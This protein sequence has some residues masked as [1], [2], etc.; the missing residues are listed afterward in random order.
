[1]IA[2]VGGDGSLS[3][4]I[5]GRMLLNGSQKETFA[6]IPAGT[7][8]SQAHDLKITSTED[9]V[10]A[11]VSGRTQALDLAKVELTE[12]LPGETGGGLIRYSHNLVTWGLGVDSTIQAEKMRWMGP[13]RYD[14]G[15]LLAIMANRRRTATLSLDGRRITDDFTLF[16]VQNSQTGAPNFPWLRVRRWTMGKWTSAFSRK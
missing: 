15:I 11:I 14:V 6:I 9:A 8:N 16:L 5:T 7:G 4:V 10:H 2:V 1:M 3:E 12:G 13:V